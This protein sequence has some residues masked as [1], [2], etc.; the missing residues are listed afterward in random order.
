MGEGLGRSFFPFPNGHLLE[1]PKILLW[2]FYLFG[3]NLVLTN[4]PESF[5]LS[6]FLISHCKLLD[7]IPFMQT[8]GRKCLDGH[9]QLRVGMGDGEHWVSWG[10]Q[11][12]QGDLGDE[13]R[14]S[15]YLLCFLVLSPLAFLL[16]FFRI[17]M[18]QVPI[19][20]YQVGHWTYQF[21]WISPILFNGL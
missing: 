1:I 17:I 2:E 5:P 4:G 8:A 20:A 18:K 9:Q 15:K 11:L 10:L 19:C 13:G 21:R 6:F 3:L 14:S 16:V 12:G 7:Y